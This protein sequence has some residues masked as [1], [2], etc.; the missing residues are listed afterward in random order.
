M[1][2]SSEL[3]VE[4]ETMRNIDAASQPVLRL[5]PIC[6]PPTAMPYVRFGLHR[7]YESRGSP[8]TT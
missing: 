6:C 3:F 2:L 8:S 4:G 5:S 7:L 1:G